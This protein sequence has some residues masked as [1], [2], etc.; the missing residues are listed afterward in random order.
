M[1]DFP[2]SLPTLVSVSSSD[3]MNASGKE[4]DVVHNQT[5]DELAAALAKIGIDDS[6]DSTTL[7]FRTRAVWNAASG[8]HVSH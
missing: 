6:A 1:A 4:H 8:W 5:N 2:T 3:S 7:D